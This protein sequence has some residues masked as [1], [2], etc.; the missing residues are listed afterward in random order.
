LLRYDPGATVPRHR[1]L[2]EEHIFVLSGWQE[3]QTGIQGK[4]IYSFNPPGSEHSVHSP[5]G[6]LVWIHWNGAIEFLNP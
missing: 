6:C 1:H 2:G 4:G 5:N 3:D